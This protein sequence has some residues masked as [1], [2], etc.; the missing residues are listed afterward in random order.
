MPLAL[1]VPGKWARK[2]ATSFLSA[3]SFIVFLFLDSLDI[4][5]CI[6]YRYL[7]E[8]FEGKATPCYCEHNAEQGGN[9][10]DAKQSE[11]SETLYERRNVFRQMGF[12]E[13]ARKWEDCKK[14]C[15]GGGMVN[16]WS[17]CACES[18]VSW[19]KNG[20]DQ[21]LHVVLREPSRGNSR[22]KSLF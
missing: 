3:V 16:R 1:L 10:G 14:G 13:F 7:D 21:K 12:L 15:G 17:D 5:L 4:I 6:I 9:V 8:F 18:C 22:E 2:S 11:L 19:M 20:D